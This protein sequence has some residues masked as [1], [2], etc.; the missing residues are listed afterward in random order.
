MVGLSDPDLVIAGRYRC[1]WGSMDET[2]S[3]TYT[4]ET[5]EIN[6]R[7]AYHSTRSCKG[8]IR[9]ESNPPINEPS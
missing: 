4:G 1:S 6:G 3:N 2:I 9:C 7:I 8:D 5:I